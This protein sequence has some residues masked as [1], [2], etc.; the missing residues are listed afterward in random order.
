MK[1]SLMLQCV[2]LVCCTPHWT[3]FCFEALDLEEMA[4]V[5]LADLE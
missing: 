2:G 4:D 1:I 5:S 3:V